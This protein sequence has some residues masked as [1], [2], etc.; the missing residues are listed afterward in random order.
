MRVILLFLL[1]IV[2]SPVVAQVELTSS[3]NYTGSGKNI[4]LTLSKT[5]NVKHEFGGG[6]RYNINSLAHRDDQSNMYKGRLYASELYQH[7]GVVGFYHY[8]IYRN[9]EHIHPFLFYDFQATYSKTRNHAFLPTGFVLEN[10]HRLYEEVTLRFGPF[11]WIE[12]CIGFGYKVDLPQNFFI[13][14]KIGVG[15]GLIIGTDEQLL[16]EKVTWEFSGLINIGI[17]YRFK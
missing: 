12:Q 9:W 3:F 16:K 6:L 10:G 7:Y 17:G 13:S 11:T 8:N 2:V 14:Q 4:T 15:G 1:F 5:Y